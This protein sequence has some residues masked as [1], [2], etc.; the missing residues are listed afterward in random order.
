MT[1]ETPLTTNEAH[2]SPYPGRRFSVDEYR[3]MGECG[4]LTIEDRV[5]LLEGWVVP[6]MMHNPA[7]DGTVA[8]VNEAI[9]KHLPTG[10]H[11]R[12]QSAIATSDSQPEPDLAITRGR[13]RDFLERHPGPDDIA[14]VIEVADTSLDRDRDKR[15]LYARAGIREY[16][17]VNLLERRIEVYSDPT[18]DDPEPAFRQRKDY[19][20]AS[21]VPLVI[22]PASVAQLAVRSLLP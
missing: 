3:R 6:K 4:I 7:H 18:G 12:I 11:V 16:W 9:L 15:R 22:D 1:L 5:E 13:G 8:I 20:P 14:L 2:F 19:D 10:W 21:D 17:I